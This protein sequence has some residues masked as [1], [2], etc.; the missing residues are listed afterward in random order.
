MNYINIPIQI[1]ADSKDEKVSTEMKKNSS[2]INCLH[3]NKLDNTGQNSILNQKVKDNSISF[4]F[5]NSNFLLKETK[6]P[7]NRLSMLK[8]PST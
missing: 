3:L 1:K 7:S 5:L 8:H 2:E 6:N 4:D